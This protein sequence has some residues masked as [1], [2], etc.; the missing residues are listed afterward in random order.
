MSVAIDFTDV[1]RMLNECAPGHT[2]RVTNHFRRIK[3][4][5]MFY[6]SLP[7]HKRIEIGHIHKMIRHFKIEECAKKYGLF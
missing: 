6:P 7:K 1:Q 4:G 2:I 3:F 5:S